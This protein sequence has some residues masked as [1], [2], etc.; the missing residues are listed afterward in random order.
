[1]VQKELSNQYEVELH[2]QILKVCHKLELNLHDNH[3]DP[4]IYTNY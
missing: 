2:Q 1:M 4:N 3:Y